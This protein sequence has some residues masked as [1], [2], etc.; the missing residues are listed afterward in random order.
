[1]KSKEEE[2]SFKMPDQAVLNIMSK[3]LP[4]KLQEISH[5]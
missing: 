2:S 3:G 4:P 1:M 5:K